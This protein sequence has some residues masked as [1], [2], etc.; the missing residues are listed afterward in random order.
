M[1]N[2]DIF[3]GLHQEFSHLLFRNSKICFP[4]MVC[5]PGIFF[6]YYQKFWSMLSR[7][8]YLS[9]LGIF[10]ISVLVVKNM[11]VIVYCPGGFV[12][13]AFLEFF[14]Y[15]YRHFFQIQNLHIIFKIF[16][17]IIIVSGISYFLGFWDSLV[18]FRDFLVIWG[19]FPSNS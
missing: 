14:Q 6:H 5:Y 8:F 7:N 10:L 15:L 13:R 11:L 4:Q 19:D 18:L 3:R 2:K 1:K 9:C 17:S 12:S 16:K